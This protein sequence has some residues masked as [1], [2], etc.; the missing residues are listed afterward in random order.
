MLICTKFTIDGTLWI[1][2]NTPLHVAVYQN[3]TIAVEVLLKYNASINIQN[4]FGKI[5]HESFMN[6]MLS[7]IQYI[8]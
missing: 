3:D 5:Y 2:G 6:W 4:D 8:I 7:K 1:L